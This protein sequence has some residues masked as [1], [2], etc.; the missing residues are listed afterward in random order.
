VAAPEVD[1]AAYERFA[2]AVPAAVKGY[3]LVQFVALNL[4]TAWFLNRQA[5][6][7]PGVRVAA[8]LA[9]VLSVVSLGGLLDRRGWAPLVEG[10]RAAGL[11]GLAV[12]LGVRSGIVN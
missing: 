10:V 12:Y 9:I 3:V 4:L 5:A 2:V 11:V 7:A 1:R 6:L 8:S